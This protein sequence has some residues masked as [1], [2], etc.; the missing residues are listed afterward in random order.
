MSEIV[1]SIYGFFA[2]LSGLI[3]SLKRIDVIHYFRERSIELKVTPI[4]LTILCL[5][6]LFIIAIPVLNI[7]YPIIHVFCYYE[8]IRDEFITDIKNNHYLLL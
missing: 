4:N 8:D 5:K 7:F 2:F 1:L 6:C 3:F